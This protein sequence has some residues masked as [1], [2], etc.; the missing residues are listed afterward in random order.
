[1]RNLCLPQDFCVFRCAALRWEWWWKRWWFGSGGYGHFAMS[2][3]RFRSDSMGAG[4]ASGPVQRPERHSCRPAWCYSYWVCCYGLLHAKAV[5][6]RTGKEGRPCAAPMCI[7]GRKGVS[8]IPFFFQYPSCV[9]RQTD[10]PV[11]HRLLHTEKDPE[12]EGERRK[13]GDGRGKGLRSIGG[14]KAGRGGHPSCICVACVVGQSEA[15]RRRTQKA[16]SPSYALRLPSARQGAIRDRVKS[17]KRA[18]KQAGLCACDCN[19]CHKDGF[20]FWQ[21]A[22]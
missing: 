16:L 21:W 13:V 8:P 3:P 22:D 4:I 17:A 10:R 6:S 5:S 18:R 14:C 9:G 12:T 2:P 1:M 15:Q 20:C 7:G 19:G 11:P